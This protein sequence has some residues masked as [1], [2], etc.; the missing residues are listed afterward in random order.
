MLTELHI[1]KCDLSVKG[2][3]SG[4]IT[5]AKYIHSIVRDDKW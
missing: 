1:Q 4:Y 5:L 2:M 3:H